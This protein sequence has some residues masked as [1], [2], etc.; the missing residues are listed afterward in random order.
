M[1]IKS[2]SNSKPKKKRFKKINR[3]KKINKLKE[4]SSYQSSSDQSS[5]NQYR[6]IPSGF[7]IPPEY[8]GYE[9]GTW[10]TIC[11]CNKCNTVGLYED[12]NPVD[13][14]IR[15]G[16]KDKKEEIGRW[17]PPVYAYSTQSFVQKLLKRKSKIVTEGYWEMCP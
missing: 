6:L 14:C 3:P 5:S 12:F 9:A 11:I 1:D 15:C 16:A 13:P 4:E 8:H 2:S 7:H 17:I 10:A